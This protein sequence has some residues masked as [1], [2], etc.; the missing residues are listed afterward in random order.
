MSIV[1]NLA[2][3]EVLARIAGEG[4]KLCLTLGALAEIE[5]AFGTTSWQGLIDRIHKLSPGDLLV[6]LSAL[7]KGGGEHE[8]AAKLAQLPVNLQEA[9]QAIAQAF[10]AATGHEGA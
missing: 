2:R 10:T 9:A 1:A 8:A 5:S 6:V 4:R 7:L 3:G